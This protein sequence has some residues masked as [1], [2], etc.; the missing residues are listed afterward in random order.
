MKLLI[1]YAFDNEIN[2]LQQ[3]LSPK[4]MR[5]ANCTY[6]QRQINDIDIFLAKTGIGTTRAAVIT[7][8]LSLA[9]KPDIIFFIGTAGGLKSGLHTGDLL[10]GDKIIDID[11]VHLPDILKDTPYSSCL[12]EPHHDMPIK[13]V[14]QLDPT[15]LSHFMRLAFP[16]TFAGTIATSNTFPAPKEALAV[17]K[18][19]D[20]TIIEME[21]SGLSYAAFHDDTPLVVVRAVSNNL[22]SN[23]NDLGTPDDAIHQ[24]AVRLADFMMVV[25]ETIPDLEKI[26]V[27]RN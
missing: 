25:L 12:I 5:I 1:L 7:T 21:G 27:L 2:I 8:R 15:L 26:S 6:Y 23:G 16:K 11:L 3:R 13:L 20:S 14:Y 18:S 19:H 4:A 10:I 9:L 22:D 17:M 24:C